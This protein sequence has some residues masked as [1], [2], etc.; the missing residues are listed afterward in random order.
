MAG[1][2]LPSTVV[3]SMLS[4]MAVGSE[5]FSTMGGSTLSS[6][7]KPPFRMSPVWA[8]SGSP[9]ADALATPRA[10]PG[11]P[12]RRRPQG[13]EGW[14]RGERSRKYYNITTSLFRL[15]NQFSCNDYNS[16]DSM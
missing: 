3:D 4:S 6:N 10:T 1:S 16:P 15:S 14:L 13:Q 8:T 9:T 11:C 12:E 2:M 5:L 7:H